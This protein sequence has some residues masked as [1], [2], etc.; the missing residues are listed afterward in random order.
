VER[1][2]TYSYAVTAV[3]RATR[4]NESARSNEV[5]ATVP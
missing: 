1:G 2:R 3:D 4:P 5:T